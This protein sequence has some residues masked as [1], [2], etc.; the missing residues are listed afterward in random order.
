MYLRT[1]HKSTR[2][3][4][5]ECIHSCTDLS[6]VIVSMSVLIVQNVILPHV[7]LWLLLMNAVTPLYSIRIIMSSAPPVSAFA[8]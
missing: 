8:H 7:S 4:C 1:R 2:Y 3:K 5:T 6:F